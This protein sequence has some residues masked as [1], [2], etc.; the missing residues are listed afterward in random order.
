MSHVFAV[1]L[2]IAF[3]LLSVAPASWAADVP[4][5]P[6]PNRP[7]EPLAAKLSLGRAASVLDARA[8]AWTREHK[9]GSCH[10]TYPYLLARPALK[11]APEALA[12]I[13]QFF[14][15]RATNW[16]RGQKGDAPRWDT[17]VVATALVLAMDDA[18]AGKLRPV[19]RQALDR[20]WTLQKPSGAWDWLKCNWPP[21]EHDDYYGATIGALAAGLAPE[22][23]ADTP[24]ARAGLEQLRK[25]FKA[26][27]PPDTHHKA[28]LLWASTR[29]NGLMSTAEKEAAIKELLALQ[30]DDGGWCLPSLGTWKRRD[31]SANDP[32]APSDGYATGLVVYVL[33]QAG[34]PA[35]DQRLQKAVGWLQANQRESG[36]WFTRSLNNDKAHYVTDAGTSFAVLALEACGWTGQ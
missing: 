10:T 27:P 4:A 7:D 1:R 6:G 15:D 32:K 36:R 22:G 35:T 17:E 18:R 25:Y 33:R 13:R 34:V 26:N 29:V 30:R 23:Y 20:A 24:K 21:M 12:E 3:L 2:P 31:G 16:D 28:M 5:K 19:T 8:L 14:V 11:G 9:C